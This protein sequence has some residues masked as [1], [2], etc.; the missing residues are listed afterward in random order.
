MA[1]SANGTVIAVSGKQMMKSTSGEE[2]MTSVVQFWT[3]HGIMRKKLK[4][5]GNE[6]TAISW[7]ADTQRIAISADSFIFFANVR[8]DHQW[9]YFAN[10]T[11]VYKYNDGQDSDPLLIF[12]NFVKNEKKIKKFSG[13]KQFCSFGECCLVI[14]HEAESGNAT[15]SVISIC[16][17]IG[18]AIETRK[19]EIEAK[20]CSLG[21]NQFVVASSSI[22]L[23]CSLKSHIITNGLSISQESKPKALHIDDLRG[24]NDNIDSLA[25]KSETD[26]PITCIAMLNSTLIVGRESGSILQFTIPSLK[27]IERYESHYTPENI[28][29]NC[30]GSKL[31]V[32]SSGGLLKILQLQSLDKAAIAAVSG[33]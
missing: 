2:K 15:K 23:Q 24:G 12:W 1:W 33:Y 22:I 26:D 7:D 21:M 31:S 4:V 5:P 20:F 10:N 14:Q 17:A 29:L 8:Q 32:I 6:I 30:K 16:N 19:T 13:L 27:L 25:A 11:L 3:C 18:T 9:L 28:A